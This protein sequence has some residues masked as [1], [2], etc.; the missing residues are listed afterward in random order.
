MGALPAL[1]GGLSLGRQATQR[2]DL[3]LAADS[4]HNRGRRAR[5]LLEA[6]ELNRPF[7]EKYGFRHIGSEMRQR[8]QERP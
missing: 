4:D 3:P 1:A 2:R 8:L 6:T 5:R 7:Y